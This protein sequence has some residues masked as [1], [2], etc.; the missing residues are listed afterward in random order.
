MVLVF[1]EIFFCLCLPEKGQASSWMSGT[2]S[3]FLKR[4]KRS[5]AVQVKTPEDK[6]NKEGD[7]IGKE[8]AEG[9]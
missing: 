8:L 5:Q 2:A 1:Y 9:F 6:F 7:V 3:L 4:N